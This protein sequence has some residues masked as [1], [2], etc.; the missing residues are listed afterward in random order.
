MSILKKFVFVLSITFFLFTFSALS[1]YGETEDLRERLNKIEKTVNNLIEVI[2][3]H[4]PLEA[5]KDFA[6]QKNLYLGMKDDDVRNLQIVL[7]FDSDTRVAQTGYGSPGNETDYFGPA[8][9]DAV[10]RFQE[11]YKDEVLDPVGMDSPN[12]FVGSHSRAK[13]NSI[14]EEIAYY[15]DLLDALEDVLERIEGIEEKIDDLDKEDEK[16]DSDSEPF[17]CI[18]PGTI[19]FDN[20]TE[21]VNEIASWERVDDANNGYAVEYQINGGDWE[22]ASLGVS[23]RNTPGTVKTTIGFTQFGSAGN[24]I[25]LRVKSR[26]GD[27]LVSSWRYSTT[28]TVQGVD[29][30]CNTPSPVNFSNPIKGEDYNASWPKVE[31]AVNGYDVEY[32]INSD[33]YSDPWE[34]LG[35][36][37]QPSG[38]TVNFT[39]PKTLFS[40]EGDLV[41]IRVK[42]K[43]S[44]SESEWRIVPN[45]VVKSSG[46]CTTSDHYGTDGTIDGDTV[47]CDNNGNLWSTTVDYKMQWSDAVSYCNSISYAGKTNWKLPE[48]DDLRNDFG[49][50][51]CGWEPYTGHLGGGSG[52]SSCLSFEW[53]KDGTF[54]QYW[55]ITEQDHSSAW[56]IL[57]DDGFINGGYKGN[58]YHVRCFHE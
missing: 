43:C 39:I 3:D 48:W 40:N 28:R 25:R 10:K 58:E 52:Q 34:S 13:L 42:S 19:T 38:N 5:P 4:V 53:D 15:V 37:S 44:A 47:F 26:C 24:T 35:F 29:L 32:Q 23:Q 21:G 56:H 36:V 51:A 33:W 30:E 49:S 54:L 20:P 41:S 27:D 7:N 1:T 9:K 6:F 11:K 17:S 46:F 31:N 14:L 45:R 57:F 16:E 8:T 18:R 22:S 12:G 50:S 55:T 2:E